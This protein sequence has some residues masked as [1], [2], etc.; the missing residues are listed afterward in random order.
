MD[1]RVLSLSV[2]MEAGRGG[3]KLVLTFARIQS[4][5]GIQGKLSAGLGRQEFFCIC[6]QTHGPFTWRS[7]D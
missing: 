4:E 7:D 3:T 5:S 2:L 1:D 6:L